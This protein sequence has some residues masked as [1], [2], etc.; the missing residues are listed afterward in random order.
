[1]LTL[2]KHVEST[3]PKHALWARLSKPIVVLSSA[4]TAILAA[5]MTA[6]ADT[7]YTPETFTASQ[8]DSIFTALNAQFNVTFVLAV[9]G[10]IIGAAAALVAMWWGARKG[11]RML[12]SAFKRG[13]LRI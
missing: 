12:M 11:V 6:S 10:A 8:L 13:K 4:G 5:G 7:T 9:L 1:M 2:S 3:E